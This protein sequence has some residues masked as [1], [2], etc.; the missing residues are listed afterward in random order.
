MKSSEAFPTLDVY[1]RILDLNGL[2]YKLKLVHAAG[3]AKQASRIQEI[4]KIK[5]ELELNQALAE[6]IKLHLIRTL[7]A[8]SASCERLSSSLKHVNNYLRCSHSE[9]QESNL[10][11][12]SMNKDLLKKV[13]LIFLTKSLMNLPRR[14]KLIGL[15]WFLCLMAYQPF[16]RSFNAKAILLEEQ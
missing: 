5:W 10:V 2:K 3:F 9:E 7:P 1:K 12:I 13:V 15:V 4:S 6:V 11:F 8:T 14:N 16:F